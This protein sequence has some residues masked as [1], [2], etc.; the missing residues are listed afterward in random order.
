MNEKVSHG[1]S[2][3]P[4]INLCSRD[5]ALAIKRTKKKKPPTGRVEES[6]GAQPTFIYLL[7]DVQLK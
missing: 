6:L 5:R 3:S 4:D 2:P 1:F 7:I